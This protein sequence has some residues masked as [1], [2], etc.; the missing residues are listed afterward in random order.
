[1]IDEFEEEDVTTHPGGWHFLV[2]VL[3]G[4]LLGVGVTVINLT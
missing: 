3:T 4:V 1:M 2:G